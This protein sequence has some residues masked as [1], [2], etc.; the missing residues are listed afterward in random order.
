[1]NLY[2]I[3]NFALTLNRTSLRFFHVYFTLTILNEINLQARER[4]L[5]GYFEGSDMD[6]IRCLNN[7]EAIAKYFSLFHK[8]IALVNVLKEP[9]LFKW[10][11]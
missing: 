1:M 8:K 3:N 7:N 11:L 4:F 9:V 6:H 10:Q 5:F 2:S